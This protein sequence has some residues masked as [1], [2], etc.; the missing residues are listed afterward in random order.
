VLSVILRSCSFFTRMC[1]ASRSV[2]TLLATPWLNA[3]LSNPVPIEKL[4]EEEMIE[5]SLLKK[6]TTAA[7]AIA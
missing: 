4:E 1:L 6:A 7:A 5:L 2:F 3:I